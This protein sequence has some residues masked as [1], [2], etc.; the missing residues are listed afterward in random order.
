MELG[1]LERVNPSVD[2]GRS[3]LE[4]DGAARSSVPSTREAHV[5]LELQP[6]ALSVAGVT[7]SR[8]YAMLTTDPTSVVLILAADA[9]GASGL[10]HGVQ[11]AQLTAQNPRVQVTDSSSFVFYLVTQG[12]STGQSKPIV[13]MDAVDGAGAALTA[14][15][16]VPVFTSTATA[17]P[18]QIVLVKTSPA[19]ITLTSAVG[20]GGQSLVIKDASGQSFPNI[21]VVPLPGQTVDNTTSVPINVALGSRRFVS[22]GANWWTID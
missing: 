4:L 6:F 19:T 5:H 16:V 13:W 20:V 18:G 15:S 11:I 1:R 10:A 14:L 12:V 9:L 22:D 3:I 21:T 2:P 7:S 8:S 17:S